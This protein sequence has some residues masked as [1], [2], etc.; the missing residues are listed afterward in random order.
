MLPSRGVSAGGNPDEETRRRNVELCTA[1]T[2]GSLCRKDWLTPAQ[3]S[4]T[5]EAER[6]HN[7]TLCLNGAYPSLCRRALL[8][9]GLRVCRIKRE[10]KLP[11]MATASR[12]SALRS[13]KHR[14]PQPSARQH[15]PA[16]HV[17]GAAPPRPRLRVRLAAYSSILVRAPV[18]GFLLMLTA[19]QRW[20][21][22]RRASPDGPTPQ[23]RPQSTRGTVL[24]ST[25]AG[26]LER[27]EDDPGW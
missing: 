6:R 20:P 21:R 2:Y 14:V 15:A 22:F 10:F 16:Q 23:R 18:R 12:P 4:R 5:I 27:L 7:L 24:E 8:T 3:L 1:R 9:L 11:V 26:R 19:R 25:G 13:G 17:G